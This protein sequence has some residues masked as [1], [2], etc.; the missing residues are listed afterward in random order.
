[1]EIVDQDDRGALVCQAPRRV[2][3]DCLERVLRQ[4]FCA[5]RCR[6]TLED[7]GERRDQGGRRGEVLLERLL[8]PLG[9]ELFTVPLGKRT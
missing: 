7:R 4:R 9:T 6:F 3:E 5:L 2:H 8:E 1:M